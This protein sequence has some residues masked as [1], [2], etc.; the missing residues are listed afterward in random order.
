MHALL[1]ER[2]DALMGGTEGSS[3]EAELAT[4][5]DAIE[6]YEKVRWPDGRVARGKGT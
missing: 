3:K 4:L 6:A 1:V 2:A 5:T